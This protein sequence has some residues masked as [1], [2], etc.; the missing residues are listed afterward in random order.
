VNRAPAETA[1]GDSLRTVRR[2]LAA[3]LVLGLTGTATELVLLRHYEDSWQLV[4]MFFIAAALVVLAWHG[5]RP[6]AASVRLLQ[7]T[8]AGFVLVSGIGLVLHYQ[9]SLEFQLEVDPGLHG[10]PLFLK[11]IRA[12]APPALAPGVMAQLGLIGL[13]YAFRHPALAKTSSSSSNDFRSV[14]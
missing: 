6:S 11:V 4:P 5:V 9:G 10:W 8:M 1:P 7:A 14:T 12:Q 3:V 2:I 13:A